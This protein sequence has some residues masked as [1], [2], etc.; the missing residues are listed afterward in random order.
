MCKRGLS[1]FTFILPVYLPSTRIPSYMI[2][3][4]KYIFVGKSVFVGK[5]TKPREYRLCMI[6]IKGVTD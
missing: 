5:D 6:R 1:A 2:C 4:I 3:F